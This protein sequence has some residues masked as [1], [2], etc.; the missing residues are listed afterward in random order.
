VIEPSAPTDGTPFP[1]PLER[2]RPDLQQRCTPL[3][4]DQLRLLHHLL[5]HSLLHRRR[6][7]AG[8]DPFALAVALAIRGDEPLG[9]FDGCTALLHHV[10]TLLCEAIYSVP[11]STF[12]TD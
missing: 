8:A 5:A 4:P 7:T 12:F 6:D 11:V 1:A 2:L 3:T 9:V 10:Q